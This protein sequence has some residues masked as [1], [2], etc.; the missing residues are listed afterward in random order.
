MKAT[1]QTYNVKGKLV[2]EEEVTGFL[3]GPEPIPSGTL[4]DKENKCILHVSLPV[5]NSKRGYNQHIIIPLD[6]LFGEVKRK[7]NVAHGDF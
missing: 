4:Q 6:N 5:E 2:K 1:L 3:T 7:L